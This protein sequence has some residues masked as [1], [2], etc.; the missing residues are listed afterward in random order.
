MRSQEAIQRSQGKIDNRSLGG[1]A[2]W[3]EGYPCVIQRR[4]AYRLRP[5]DTLGVAESVLAKRALFLFF[6]RFSRDPF[7]QYGSHGMGRGEEKQGCIEI[8]DG[9]LLSGMG[10]NPATLDL[11]SPRH[12]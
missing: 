6:C 10:G 8:R 2:L 12:F 5:S 1:L 3:V 11:A 4:S 7:T 9:M